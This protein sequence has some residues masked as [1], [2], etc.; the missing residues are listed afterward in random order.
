MSEAIRLLQEGVDPKRIDTLSKGYGFP[1]GVATLIDEVG[2]DVAA[3]VAEDLGKAYGE[4]FSGGNPEV[5]KSM[6]AA[7]CL[8]RKSGKGCYIYDD[9]KG[10]RPLNTEA[11]NIFKQFSLKPAEYCSADEDLQ[12][13]LV[14]RFVNES[15]YSLQDGVLRTALE[16]DIGAVFGLGFPPMHGGP[17][18]Y[19][20]TMGAQKVVDAMRKFENAYGTPFTPCQLLLDMAKSG[21]KFY[22][23]K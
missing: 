18:R 3:H 4:R 9:T 2:V 10:E 15:V 19:V 21:D 14:T 5:L 12:L 16:G 17:F 20:D 1:V 23:A 7:N 8:G 11:E 6:V 13:R 22:K